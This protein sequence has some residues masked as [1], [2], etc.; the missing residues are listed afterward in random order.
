MKPVLM[1]PEV[2]EVIT[3]ATKR[4]ERPDEAGF[5]TVVMNV[6]A[7]GMVV[8]YDAKAAEIDCGAKY[9]VVCEKHGAILGE[10]TLAGAKISMHTPEQFCSE[11]RALP[12]PPAPKK[13]SVSW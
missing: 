5:K 6:R 11:C 4:N 12:E 7:G 3:M 2:K 10:E 9:A 1:S 8:V 13:G